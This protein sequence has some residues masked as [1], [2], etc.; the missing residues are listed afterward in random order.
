M[1]LFFIIAIGGILTVLCIWFRAWSLALFIG[2]VATV[3]LVYRLSSKRRREKI[4]LTT[5]FL[6]GL[7]MGGW[8]Q[9]S[10]SAGSYEPR[11]ELLAVAVAIAIWGSV[12]AAWYLAGGAMAEWQGLKHPEGQR[13]LMATLFRFLGLPGWFEHEQKVINGQ[14]QG[15]GPMR[16]PG[17]GIVTIA[18][19]SA[20]IFEY[21]GEMFPI[22]EPGIVLT[23]PGE[24]IHAIFDLRLH[25]RSMDESHEAIYSRDGVP[26]RVKLS[27][28]YRI[29]R[30]PSEVILGDPKNDDKIEPKTLLRA[31]N[32]VDGW[33]AQTEQVTRAALREI[34]SDRPLDEIFDLHATRSDS[35]WLKLETA[36]KRRVA[37]QAYHWGVEIKL[38]TLH[39]IRCPDEVE[40]R[41]IENWNMYR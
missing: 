22:T 12:V 18:G 8:A 6:L 10:L 33:E 11:L 24:V 1:G 13:L 5:L 3:G 29:R 30:G 20:V 21:K 15:N 7:N 25:Y 41:L 23:R 19:A 38:I 26:L 9:T 31:A 37:S 17:P 39:E 4:T 40:K 34:L 28:H 35:P 14:L 32:I 27:V 16:K 36:I 2:S